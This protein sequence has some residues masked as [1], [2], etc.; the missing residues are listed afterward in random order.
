MHHALCNTLGDDS[1]IAWTPSVSLA[2]CPIACVLSVSA[3]LLHPTSTQ[4]S[5]A[6]RSRA[7]AGTTRAS[8]PARRP[9]V[10]HRETRIVSN[11]ISC[12]HPGERF[13]HFTRFH[14]LLRQSALVSNLMTLTADGSR[15]VVYKFRIDFL[16]H[17]RLFATPACVGWRRVRTGRVD[18]KVVRPHHLLL[19]YF[20]HVFISR[21]F[22]APKKGEKSF[23][24]AA[25]A[26]DE[27][28]Q[29]P[30]AA[31][32][33]MKMSNKLSDGCQAISGHLHT[34][35]WKWL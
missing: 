18:F 31:C 28:K 23:P 9:F 21:W 12:K 13:I 33:M 19:F 2:A 15:W 26:P 17:I 14:E 20:I 1:R 4:Q 35:Q 32:S 25:G 29:N 30:T 7:E 3:A 27:T 16:K 8:S 11:G 5:R 10:P 24:V 6:E 34:T 22:N